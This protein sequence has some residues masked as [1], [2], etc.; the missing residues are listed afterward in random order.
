MLSINQEGSSHSRGRYT[1]QLVCTVYRRESQTGMVGEPILYTKRQKQMS[2][3]LNRFV[4]LLITQNII[5]LASN[6]YSASF[7]QGT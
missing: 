7:A 4:E 1:V 5:S 6:A 2:K 3:R